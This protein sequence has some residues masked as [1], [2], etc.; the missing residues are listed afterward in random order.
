MAAIA[1]LHR[2]VIEASKQCG[3]NRLMEIS[4]ARQWSDFV[5][6]APTGAIRW[7]AHRDG[8]NSIPSPN[9]S[10]ERQAEII[11]AIGPEGGFTQDEVAT[12]LAAGW[13]QLDL[14]RRILRVETAAIAV[15]ASVAF[16]AEGLQP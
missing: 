14:G 7:V 9:R 13:R 3:R 2:T 10:A 8:P 16:C 12:A 1:R 4:D 5:H 6:R 11:V 15:A